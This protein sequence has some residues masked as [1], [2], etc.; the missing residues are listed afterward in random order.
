MQRPDCDDNS[1][2][3]DYDASS[4]TAR[5]NDWTLRGSLFHEPAATELPATDSISIRVSKDLAVADLE[6]RQVRAGDRWLSTGAAVRESLRKAGVHPLA[7]DSVVCVASGKT[8]F[9]V[10]NIQQPNRNR[11]QDMEPAAWLNLQW[12][13][14]DRAS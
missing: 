13:G 3:T 10:P 1:I 6:V 5:G 8:V 2:R 9:F 14:V 12:T 4:F 11:D 7:R